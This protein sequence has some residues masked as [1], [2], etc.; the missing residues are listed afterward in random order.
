[1]TLSEFFSKKVG[2]EFKVAMVIQVSKTIGLVPVG[3]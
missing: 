1:M 3:S 2:R